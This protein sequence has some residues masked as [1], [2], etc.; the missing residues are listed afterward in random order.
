MARQ[1]RVIHERKSILE[2]LVAHG[3]VRDC[4]TAQ[5]KG[6]F[7][8]RKIGTFPSVAEAEGACRD[9]A[10]GVLLPGGGRVVS[11]FERPD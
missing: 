2:A 10:G 5:A 11:E 6:W 3:G 7:G 9:H 1:Y 8:W 4:Y